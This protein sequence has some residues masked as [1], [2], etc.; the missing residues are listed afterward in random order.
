M[1]CG[2]TLMPAVVMMMTNGDCAAVP[3]CSWL[4]CRSNGSLRLMHMPMS[5][6]AKTSAKEPIRLD[7]RQGGERINA[8]T[9]T[10]R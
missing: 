4:A 3:V 10:I 9:R 7:E 6:T 1:M 5:S 8:Q 2:R